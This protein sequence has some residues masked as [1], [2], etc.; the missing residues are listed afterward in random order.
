MYTS[1]QKNVHRL[2]FMSLMVL[3]R[4]RQN[5]PPIKEPNSTLQ[6]LKLIEISTYIRLTKIIKGSNN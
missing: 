2:Q 3:F 5:V 6:N 4:K 1:V